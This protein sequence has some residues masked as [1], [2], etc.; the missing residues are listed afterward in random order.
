V[1]LNLSNNK[2][3]EC[4]NSVIEQYNNEK[5]TSLRQFSKEEMLA[6]IITKFEKMYKV[7]EKQGFK[8]FESLY[9]KYWLHKYN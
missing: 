4:I 2:P 3:T 7:F 8:L 9:Y 1:G 5:G 6:A